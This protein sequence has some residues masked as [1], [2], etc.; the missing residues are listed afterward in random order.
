MAQQTIECESGVDW[1]VR[2]LVS[3]GYLNVDISHLYSEAKQVEY[4]Y[5]NNEIDNALAE[6]KYNNK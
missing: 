2:N 3:D 6:Y 5:M 1:L 4:D